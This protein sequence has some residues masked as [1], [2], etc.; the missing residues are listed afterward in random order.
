MR[1]PV[2]SVALDIGERLGIP[3][4]NM[5][6]GINYFER[7]YGQTYDGMPL[8]SHLELDWL[9]DSLVTLPAGLTV[10]VC[11][12]GYANDLETTYRKNATQEMQVLCDPRAPHR[13]C[14]SGNKTLRVRQWRELANGSA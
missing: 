10:L 3:L 6:P 13:P 5:C 2:R 9:I 1:E 8:P 12:P 7:F 14:R 4:R 11:H